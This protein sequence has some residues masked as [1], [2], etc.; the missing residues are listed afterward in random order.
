M[1]FLSALIIGVLIII[2]YL[3]VVFLV[4]NFVASWLGVAIVLATVSAA[5]WKAFKQ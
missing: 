4:G 1:K 5:C 3:G 2:A